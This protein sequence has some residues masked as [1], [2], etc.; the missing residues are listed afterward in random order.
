MKDCFDWVP[1]DLRVKSKMM[2]ENG[3]PTKIEIETRQNG[4]Q[5]FI[6]QQVSEYIYPNEFRIYEEKILDQDGNDLRD[7]DC[8]PYIHSATRITLEEN[9]DK[10]TLVK[11][12]IFIKPRSWLE[13]LVCHY[14][15]FKCIKTNTLKQN[16]ALKN[17]LNIHDQVSPQDF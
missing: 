13:W 15:I 5:V 12:Q 11:Y 17:Y 3:I 7:D 2:M 6:T 10:S 16:A 9:P 8:F 1:L 14:D 4:E